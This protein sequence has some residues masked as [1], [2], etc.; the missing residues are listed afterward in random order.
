MRFFGFG[1]EMTALVDELEETREA[2]SMEARPVE[3]PAVN[4]ATA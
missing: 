2:R 4:E 1:K 3:T